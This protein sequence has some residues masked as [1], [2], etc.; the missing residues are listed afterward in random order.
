MGAPGVVR[1]SA[2]PQRYLLF[3]LHFPEPEHPDSAALACC[4]ASGK[5]PASLSFEPICKEGIVTVPPSLS[6]GDNWVWTASRILSSVL[7]FRGPAVYSCFIL[8]FL[9]SSLVTVITAND[10]ECC[11]LSTYSLPGTWTLS[12]N[13]QIL[14]LLL[15]PFYLI[16]WKVFMS[17]LAMLPWWLRW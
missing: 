8:L 13:S 1:A 4:V 5:V 9:L 17:R 10:S 15:P 3:W 11:L 14:S 12:L 16:F 2:R 6:C 7:G